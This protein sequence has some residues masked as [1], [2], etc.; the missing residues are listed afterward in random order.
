MKIFN[1][2]YY[3]LISYKS[4]TFLASRSVFRAEFKISLARSLGVA[5]TPLVEELLFI[6]KSKC[7][8]GLSKLSVGDG[9]GESDAAAAISPS[10][11]WTVEGKAEARADAMSSL[12][13]FLDRWGVESFAS[14]ATYAK[15]LNLK[16]FNYFQAKKNQYTIFVYKSIWF[17]PPPKSGRSSSNPSPKTTS[18]IALLGR[19]RTGCARARGR[20]DLVRYYVV[21]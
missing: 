11:D 7:Q 19:L 13:C 8:S 14:R 4:R 21:F 5:L 1:H 9:E 10:I 17:L 2:P 3:L 6:P 15:G 16:I 20:W 18:V 12:I